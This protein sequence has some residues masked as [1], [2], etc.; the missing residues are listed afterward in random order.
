MSGQ[1]CSGGL[2]PGIR[3]LQDLETYPSYPTMD[4]DLVH[5]RDQIQFWDDQFRRSDEHWNMLQSIGPMKA[6]ACILQTEYP[7]VLTMQ[8]PSRERDSCA[9]PMWQ[10]R[11]L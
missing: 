2:Q 7:P 8:K 1:F 4:H 5:G 11:C 6:N 3:P 10:G 9:N